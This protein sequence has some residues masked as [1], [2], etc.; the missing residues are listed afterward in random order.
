MKYFSRSLAV[1]VLMAFSLLSFSQNANDSYF[2]IKIGKFSNPN[3]ADFQDLQSI[4]YVYADELDNQEFNLYLGGYGNMLQAQSVVDEIKKQNF[5]NAVVE[6][7]AANK[8]RNVS[9]VQIGLYGKNENIDWAGLEQAGK[10]YTATEDGNVRVI[11]GVYNDHITANNRA[12]ALQSKGFS[13]AYVISINSNKLHLV[14][15]FDKAV[16][17]SNPKA[18]VSGHEASLEFTAKGGGLIEEVTPPAA[19]LIPRSEPPNINKKVKRQ[20]VI[21]LQKV[22]AAFKTI[23]ADVVGMYEDQTAVAYA[24]QIQSNEKFKNYHT[25]S[26]NKQEK[27]TGYYLD[28]ADIK[29]LKTIANDMS[30]KDIDYD[31]DDL[32]SLVWYHKRASVLPKEDIQKVENWDFKIRKAVNKMAEKDALYKEMSQSFKMA[33][34]KSQILLEDYFMNKGFTLSQSRILALGALN[35]ILDGS[36]DTFI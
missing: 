18:I 27:I 14:S 23:P 10:L 16:T 35:A 19:R 24:E 29:L 1:V 9:V 22:L 36:M 8:G 5:K 6:T 15:S 21:L 25:I 2:I 33:Y 17:A 26:Q 13:N 32:R 12:E 30:A 11:T 7:K 34:F 31:E 4:G 3:I 28:W 20:S